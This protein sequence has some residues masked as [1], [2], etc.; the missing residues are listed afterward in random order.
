MEVFH[1]FPGTIATCVE[2]LKKGDLLSIAPGGVREAQFGDNTYQLMW[3]NRIGYAKVAQEA[4]VPII[5]VFTVNLRE[6]FRSL[7]L[8]QWLFQKIYDTTRLPLV[9]I[10]GGFPVKMVTIVGKPIPYDPNLTAQEL[11]DKVSSTS[12]QSNLLFIIINLL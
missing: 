11:A 8:G 2:V 5:P 4:K 3:G 7:G 9:P 10:Y 1:V 6:S 12:G